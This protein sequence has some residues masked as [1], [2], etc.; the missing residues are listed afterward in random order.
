M[1]AVED[2]SFTIAPGEVVGIAGP[3]GAGKSTIIALLTGLIPPTTGRVTVGGETPRTF[4]EQVGIGYLPELIPFNP[5]WR[6][7]EAIR[8]MAVLCGV[9]AHE[10]LARVEAVMNQVG[11]TEHRR[12]R[13]KQLSKGNLQK[14]GLAQSLLRDEQVYVFDEPTHGLDPVWTQR[15]REIVRDLRRPHRSMLVASHNLDELERVAD[16]VV[17][18]DRGRIQRIVDLRGAV[19][20]TASSYRVRVASGLQALFDAFPGAKQTEGGDV[21]IPSTNAGPLNAS[22][23][24]AIDA[25][26]VITSLN[27]DRSALEREFHAAVQSSGGSSS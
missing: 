25:G 22:L 8:R 13:C 9:P 14:V 26:A 3:N 27:P 6:A 23:A 20:E 11:L 7:E 19:T 24:R 1:R 12:K 16:R 18:I 2:V 17:I 10:T 15:F 21:L 4:A 5:L